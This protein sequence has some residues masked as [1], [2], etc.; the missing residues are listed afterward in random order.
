MTCLDWVL[1]TP[2]ENLACDE[3]LLDLCEINGADE[4]LRFWEPQSYFVVL[5]YGNRVAEEVNRE[6]CAAEKIPC[7][8][9]DLKL[10][11]AYRANEVFCTG[12][13][14]ELAGVVRIDDRIIGNGE[15]G[16]M[17]KRLSELYAKRTANDG[18][19]VTE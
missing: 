13:M 2:E 5:G 1:P 7:T 10:E 9:T 14:G 15:V 6:I 18:V 3:A 19:Q 11:D 4:I 17:T 12:T 8:E 16:V